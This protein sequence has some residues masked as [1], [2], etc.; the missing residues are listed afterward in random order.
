[1]LFPFV[2]ATVAINLFLASLIGAS[3][4]IPVLSPPLA[5]ALSAPPGVPATHAAARWIDHL[6]N[7][8]ED[9]G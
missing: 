5:L 6:L 2:A 7:Q 8:A 4:G 3:L 9:R 1:V